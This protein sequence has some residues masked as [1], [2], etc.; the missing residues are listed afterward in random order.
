MSS[1]CE[2]DCQFIL[3]K[4]SYQIESYFLIFISFN[5][6]SSYLLE[7]SISALPYIHSNSSTVLTLLL[8]LLSVWLYSDRMVCEKCEKKLSTIITPDTWKAGAKNTLE[9]GGRKL[10]ENKLLTQ[11]TKSRLAASG[12]TANDETKSQFRDCRLCKAKCHQVGSYY[13]QQCS[14]KK[15]ICSMCGIKIASTKNYMQSSAW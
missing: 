15:G 4:L 11:A 7:C 9:S 6:K 5:Y 13:C 2:T 8:T 1:P 12:S 14:Y 10:N 3:E